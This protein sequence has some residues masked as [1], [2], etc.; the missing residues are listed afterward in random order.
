[1]V[2]AAT[3]VLL[4]IFTAL[5]F[6]FMNGFHDA[7]NAIATIVVTKVL[8]P[9]QAVL[10]AAVANFSGALLFTV[11]VAKTIGK[12]IVDPSAI[13]ILIIISALAGAIIWDV[14][15]W[16]LGIPTSSSHALIGGLIGS[17]LVTTGISF[18]NWLGILKIFAFIFIAPVLGLAGAFVFA[19]VII[20][21]FR[22]SNPMKL[23]NLF[24]RLQLLSSFLYSMGHGTNDAQKTMGIKLCY[25]SL[26]A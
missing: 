17:V 1:M 6:D 14:I 26:L 7:A 4:G 10:M 9:H 25:C 3:L 5:F 15:T 2:D 20:N 23:N 16:L 22:R 11:A 13:T 19:V 24:K 21:I 18:I 12:G 8:T